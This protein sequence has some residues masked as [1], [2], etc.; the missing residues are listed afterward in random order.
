MNKTL[1]LLGLSKRAGRLAAGSFAAEQS[2]KSREA[3]LVIIACD[4]SDNTK[5]KFS[6]MAD[7]YKVRYVYFAS[8]ELLGR[9]SGRELTSVAAVTDT[10]F[11]EAIIK[12]INEINT[13][14]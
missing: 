12:R 10:G 4:A 9:F 13:Y 2:I 7:Y 14:E 1:N 11:G 3:A 6:S 5:D 8:C